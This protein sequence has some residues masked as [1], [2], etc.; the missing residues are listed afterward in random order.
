MQDHYPAP[1]MPSLDEALEQH[2]QQFGE[3][4]L[5]LYARMQDES[6]PEADR[7][8]ARNE[9]VVLNSDLADLCL[10]HAGIRTEDCESLDDDDLSQ[11]GFMHLLKK[12][13]KWKP[14]EKTLGHFVTTGLADLRSEKEGVDHLIY[15]SQRDHVRLRQLRLLYKYHERKGKEVSERTA[16]IKPGE[17][18]YLHQFALGRHR[19]DFSEVVDG[20]GAEHR[21]YIDL[22]AE[23]SFDR[24]LTGVMVANL[25]GR[26]WQHKKQYATAIAEFYYAAIKPDPKSGARRLGIYASGEYSEALAQLQKYISPPKPIER[27]E[28]RR[29]SRISDLWEISRD[30]PGSMHILR[31]R[32]RYQPWYAL[33]Y[34]H[35]T[36]QSRGFLPD[37]MM[38]VIPAGQEGIAFCG[39]YMSEMVRNANATPADF[40]A[41][42]KSTLWDGFEKIGLFKDVGNEFVLIKPKIQILSD[43][44]TR[45]SFMLV[46]DTGFTYP[47]LT[48]V[49]IQSLRY[50]RRPNRHIQHYLSCRA[51]F[52]NTK[53]DAIVN[54]Y[55]DRRKK[56]EAQVLKRIERPWYRNVLKKS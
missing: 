13:P 41:T 40:A 55:L 47:E 25:M 9:L 1:T 49:S 37:E 10:R 14:S 32:M 38:Y 3:Q 2:E 34:D 8:V 46:K 28:T 5:A 56:Y 6:L 11:L 36:H 19:G 39:H 30:S 15:L 4:N 53:N 17:S 42:D 24:V 44:E 22:A 26:L 20:P 50:K 54:E 31:D 51:V 12:I 18:R 29:R 21:Q 43:D 23:E 48:R 52:S 35:L 16:R 7:L 27:P 45:V 33:S